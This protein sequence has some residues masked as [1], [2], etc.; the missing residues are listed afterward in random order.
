ME[1]VEDKRL[2]PLLAISLIQLKQQRGGVMVEMPE[3][4]SDEKGMG[5]GEYNVTQ[6][7]FI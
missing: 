7:S 6:K 1:E 2:A 4:V 5:C 3:H